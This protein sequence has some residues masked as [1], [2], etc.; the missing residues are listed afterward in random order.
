LRKVA[1]EGGDPDAV[2]KR[3]SLSFWQAAETVHAQLVPT[4]KNAKHAASWLQMIRTYAKPL[5][6]DR[7][8]ESVTTADLLAVLAPLW[9]EQNET[10]SRL[11]QRL[12]TIFDWAKGAGQYHAENPIAG[13]KRAL[14]TV[15]RRKEHRAALAWQEVPEFIADLHRREGMSA[16]C[17][18]FLILTAARSIEARGARWAEIDIKQ[19]V[20]TVPAERMKRGI[21]HRVP[22]TLQAIE[23][24]QQVRGLDDDLVFP[25]VQRDKAGRV[26][27]MS[28]MVFK[29]LFLRMKREGFTTHG[30][31]SSFRDW[32]S[33]SAHAE[34]EVAEAALS[35][36]VGN[37]VER[38]YARSDLFE[39]R[40]KLM[41]AWGR[42][43]ADEQGNVVEMVRG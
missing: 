42:F 23:V 24:L 37:E 10:A 36:A 43:C 3:N 5:L 25:S 9:T 35:H 41:D 8:L 38:A 26:R 18:E 14:P 39:R 40:R 31:R 17:L 7:P 13:L 30:F 12:G 19:G 1:R 29:N 6:G 22:L 34:R 11:K 21:V 20:W 27:P 16:R 33:E 28:D 2:R 4:W 15:R 32:A